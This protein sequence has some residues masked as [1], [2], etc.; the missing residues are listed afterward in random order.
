LL[1][2]IVYISNIVLSHI[3]IFSIKLNLVYESKSSFSCPT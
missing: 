2:L 3:I 1:K